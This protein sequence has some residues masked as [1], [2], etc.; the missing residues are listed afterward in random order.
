MAKPLPDIPDTWPAVYQQAAPT[1]TTA[2]TAAIGSVT[3]APAAPKKPLGRPSGL[4]KR[5]YK[6]GKM[7]YTPTTPWAKRPQRRSTLREQVI[8]RNL[9]AGAT[10]IDAVLA[11]GYSPSTARCHAYRIVQRPG[12]R[13]AMI[14][15]GQRLVPAMP[16]FDGIS[17]QEMQQGLAEGLADPAAT[18]DE[19]A[20]MIRGAARIIA[21]AA[22]REER[23]RRRAAQSQPELSPASLAALEQRVAEIHEKRATSSVTQPPPDAMVRHISAAVSG[24][25]NAGPTPTRGVR[26]EQPTAAPQRPASSPSTNTTPV[27]AVSAVATEVDAE[28]AFKQQH[29]REIDANRANDMA[30]AAEL[31]ELTAIYEAQERERRERQWRE[32]HKYGFRWRP[33]R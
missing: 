8:A 15:Y 1:H 29:A 20:T 14:E 24:Q 19:L 7:V 26:P 30:A 5:P 17:S 28:G 21:E 27:D 22:E 16:D 9:I 33:Q 23:N 31:A 3:A 18:V 4:A 2:D 12:V 13:A 10:K 32:R 11:A 6:R 25:P